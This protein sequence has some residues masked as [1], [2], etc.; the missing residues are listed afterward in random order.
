[1]ISF[2]TLFKS[3]DLDT[4][5]RLSD[6]QNSL[7][8]TSQKILNMDLGA[9]SIGLYWENY[10]RAFE[11]EPWKQEENHQIKISM[12]DS[13]MDWSYRTH[14]VVGLVLEIVLVFLIIVFVG[15]IFYCLGKRKASNNRDDDREAAAEVN[16]PKYEDVI[17][18]DNDELENL[19]DLPS[20]LEAINVKKSYVQTL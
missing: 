12:S 16:P 1:M 11:G 18:K 4:R 17:K 8:I 14:D 7:E 3:S 2:L 6:N 20:Y 10:K 5:G 9:E 13:G 19:E 15:V